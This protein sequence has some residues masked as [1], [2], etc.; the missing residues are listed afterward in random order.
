MSSPAHPYSEGHVTAATRFVT[1]GGDDGDGVFKMYLGGT[2]TRPEVAYETWG[3]LNADKSNAV[4]LFTGLSPTAHACSSTEDPSPGWWEFMVGPGK[5]IDSNKFFVMCVNSLGSCFGSSGPASI[6]PDTGDLY[7][8]SFPKL[9]IEDIAK[10]GRLAAKELGIEKLLAVAG[11]SMGGMSSL[12]CAMQFPGE[13][14]YVVSISAAAAALPYAIAVRSMQRE[15]IR[16]DPD[17]NNGNYEQ[18]KEPVTGMVIGRKLGLMSYRAREEWAERFSR[19]KVP[20]DKRSDEP[21]GIEFEVES[22]LDYN[23]RK[24]IGTFDPNSYLYL[25]RTMDL[26]DVAEHGGSVKAGLSKIDAKRLMVIGVETDVLFPIDQQQELAEE[27]R[28]AGLDTVYHRLSSLNGHDSFLI[29]EELF[30]P[31]MREFFAE[32]SPSPRG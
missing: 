22:Y 8:L 18:G 12:S 1:L 32:M 26:F 25:S 6:N 16:S 17:W 2:L 10:A 4:L 28:N 3:E 19:A 9:T 13:V 11:A 7:R 27:V 30:G 24:F 20:E 14:E 15:I 5:P 31:V 21:F 23:A 29:D